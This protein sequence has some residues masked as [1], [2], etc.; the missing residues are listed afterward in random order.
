MSHIVWENSYEIGVESIDR[1]HKQ[2]FST[3]NK[4]IK[5]S[6][7]EEK[8]EWV[9]REGIKYLKNHAIVHFENEE[10]YMQSVQYSG[11]EIH[12]RLHDDFRYNTIPALEREL[13]EK[14][15]S[16]EAVRHFVAVCIGWVISHTKTEDQAIGGKGGNCWDAIPHEK[17]KEA[18]ELTIIQ[19]IE[20]L[21]K[22]KARLISEQ[23]AGENFGNVFC[24]RY[25]YRGENK[26]RW[27]VTLI[28]EERLLL[29]LVS[30]MLNTSYPKV[31]EMVL[32]L[33]RYFSRQFLESIRERFPAISLLTLENESLL[34]YDQMVK[35]F[36][37]E[38]PAY[39]LLFS[40]G[41]GY[42]G[43]STIS[44]EP[45]SSKVTP[46]FTH[47]T[48]MNAL[49]DYLAREKEENENRKYKILVVDDSDFVLGR[50][51][52]ILAKEYDLIE[53]HSSI[54]AIKKIVVNRPDL[55]LLDYEMP[56]CDGK[57][58]LEMIRSDED[59]A[60]IP[61]MFLTGRDDRESV[62]NVRT[63]K[64]EGYLLKKMS[65]DFIKKYVDDFF[66]KK[67]M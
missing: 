32:N 30:N 58:T 14:K 27:E 38:H 65:D 24:F 39:S 19:L 8:S 46:E 13:E 61:V 47:E 35:S 6:E 31:D 1:E 59:I 37:R 62:K 5:L 48:A 49:K 22:L 40:T 41:E 20:E 42:F 10:K 36:E 2:L 3:M 28:F 34:T 4:L 55:V 29:K 17:E 43:F 11:Y 18:L 64:P 23:Y 7:Q 25:S 9:C 15:Y 21:T 51:R 60:D 63:L 67:A 26:E 44:A 56:I 57:Q 33:T 52:K 50:M 54:S 53:S 16:E 12:K 66:E 45:L